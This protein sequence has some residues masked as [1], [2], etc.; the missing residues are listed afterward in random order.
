MVCVRPLQAT[1]AVALTPLVE[2]F[3]RDNAQY[4]GAYRTDWTTARCREHAGWLLDGWRNVFGAFDDEHLVGYAYLMEDGLR[5]QGALEELYVSPPYRRRGIGRLL[6]Q[7]A[8][9]G[10]SEDETLEIRVA[11]TNL[12]AIKLYEATGYRLVSQ[13]Y[14][15]GGYSPPGPVRPPT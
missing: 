2:S 4:H 6:L 13:I 1:D 11:A 3:H 8:T 10:M 14:M 9:A 7:E 12:A 15:R 5:H